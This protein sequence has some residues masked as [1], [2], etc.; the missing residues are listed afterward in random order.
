MPTAA[1]NISFTGGAKI[2]GLPLPTASSDAASK[3][4]VDRLRPG[5]QAFA[6]DSL[7]AWGWTGSAPTWISNQG[8]SGNGCIEVPAASQL[9]SVADS[10]IRVDPSASLRIAF[11]LQGNG[12]GSVFFALWP[13]DSEGRSI[14]SIQVNCPSNTLTTLAAALNPGD[15]TITLASSANWHNGST[16]SSRFI[17]FGP[18]TSG[19]VVF[20]AGGYT[21]NVGNGSHGPAWVPSSGVPDWA[22]GG[23]SGNVITLAVPWAGPAYPSGTSVGNYRA[24]ATYIYPLGSRVPPASWTTFSGVVGSV[25]AASNADL[26]RLWPGTARCRLLFFGSGLTAPFRIAGLSITRAEVIG[27]GSASAPSLPLVPASGASTPNSGWW[28]DPANGELVLS[29]LGNERFRQGISGPSFG[30]LS[31]SGSAFGILGST[32]QLS[33][34]SMGSSSQY[35][36]GDGALALLT[37][38][39]RGTTLIGFSAVNASVFDTDTIIQAFGKLQGQISNRTQFGHTHPW[40]EITSK[41]LQRR[42]ITFLAGQT[43]AVTGPFAVALRLPRLGDSGT[44]WTL[45]RLALRVEGSSSGSSSVRLEASTGSGAFSAINTHTASDLTIAG[46]GVHEVALTSFSTL[47]LTS[48]AKVRAN[49]TALDPGH[50]VWLLELEIEEA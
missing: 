9:L 3:A 6:F 47:S 38:D 19:G 8:P 25:P 14:S 28:R 12:A 30:A 45:K 43:P 39:V 1:S 49:I 48:D 35:W 17:G 22:Q 10:P 24:G 34:A 36:R 21:R 32:G 42:T 40:T 29:I 37:A 41:P 5:D 23:I 33:R 50:T 20:P 15:T 46:S 4:Y 11:S 18:F 31:G 27:D 13:F 2:T 16:G 44:T 26:V 7:T